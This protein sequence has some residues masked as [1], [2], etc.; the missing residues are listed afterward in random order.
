M[1]GTLI[2]GLAFIEWR[3]LV[4]GR[5]ALIQEACQSF[6]KWKL[7]GSLGMANNDDYG[8]VCQCEVLYKPWRSGRGLCTYGEI[9]FYIS[10]SLGMAAFGVHLFL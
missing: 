2:G 10:Y 5:Y 9:D 7:L 3:A 8:G 1:T 6:K 4:K